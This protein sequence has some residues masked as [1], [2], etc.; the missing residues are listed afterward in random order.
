MFERIQ[1]LVYVKSLYLGWV[2]KSFNG[3]MAPHTGRHS[4]GAVV[5]AMTLLPR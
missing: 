2:S 5:G 4:R 3:L 1:W